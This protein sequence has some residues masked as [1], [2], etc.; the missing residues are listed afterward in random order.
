MLNL[1][2]QIALITGSSRGIGRA[3]ALL[4]AERGACVAVNYLDEKDKAE[5]VINE[6]VGKGGEAIAVQ[7][8]VSQR[9]DCEQL[10]EKTLA[11]F[12]RID[13]LVNNAGIH[14]E[15]LIDTVD[16][17]GW[18]EIMA[19]NVK[20][21]YMLSVLAGKQMKKQ[22]KGSIINIGSVA[23]VFPRGVNTAYAASKGAVWSLTRALAISLAPEV[24]VNAV[25]PG[26]IETDMSPIDSEEKR[27]RVAGGNLRHRVGQPE[28][29][30]R[31][32]A[33]LA[34]DQADW[35]TGQTVMAEG[36]ASLI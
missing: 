6:I 1:E 13:I 4:L 18:E 26:I 5:A 21:M 35:I 2:S 7:G 16:E 15:S 17:E 32:V 33:F 22:G 9:R 10:V 23:G 29:I 3:I 25:A 36:G 19:C 12:G 24:R 11:C 31:V 8:D 28:D 34:S 14:R 27:R 20:G 30:A